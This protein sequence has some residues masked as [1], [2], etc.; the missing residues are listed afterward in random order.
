M[1]V[2]QVNDFERLSKLSTRTVD[3]FVRNRAWMGRKRLLRLDVEK[4]A[5]F[6][7]NP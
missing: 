6:P 4:I 7:S 2:V 3:N 1:K 5:R